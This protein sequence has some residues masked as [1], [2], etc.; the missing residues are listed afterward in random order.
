M[1]CFCVIYFSGGCCV[2]ENMLCALLLPTNTTGAELFK[3]LN[4]YLSGK[5]TWSFFVSICM[6]EAGSMTGQLFGFTTQV[7]EMDLNVSPR[8]V[9]SIE[10]CWLNSTTFCRMWLNLST[11]LKYMP[12]THICLPSAMKRWTQ[13]TH[14]LLYTEVSSFLNV[15]H[16]PEFLSYKTPFRDFF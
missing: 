4:D 11:T 2:H 1:A 8:T 10:K 15:D 3:S 7:K 16:W 6:G 13:H 14:L 5:L 9:S 12:L